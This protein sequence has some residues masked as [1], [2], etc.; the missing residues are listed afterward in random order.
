[1]SP[2]T[3]YNFSEKK[4]TENKVT[5]ATKEYALQALSMMDLTSLNED[6]TEQAIKEL[7]A[8][9]QNNFGHTAAVCIYPQFIKTAKQALADNEATDVKVATVT[10]F[11][12][13]ND[14]IAVAVNETIEAV[15]AGADEIDVVFPY[16]A[17]IAGNEQ[18]GAELV[19]ACKEACQSAGATLKVIIESGEL[20]T[21]TLIK[22]ASEIAIANGADFIKTSTG[23]VAVNATLETAEIMLNAIKASGK[24]VGFKAAG[25]VRSSEDAKAYIQLA[26]QIMGADWMT[27]DTFRFGASGLLGSLLA[28]L[29]DEAPAENTANY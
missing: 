16:R 2:E 11:P 14:D 20:K 24:Q 23:K 4:I 25:G 13:G 18:V 22:R 15:E 28:T 1:M 3:L 21:A 7:C 26:E 27:V 17:L 9:Q 6:D 12:H 8:K 19:K 10:N 29:N 5:E